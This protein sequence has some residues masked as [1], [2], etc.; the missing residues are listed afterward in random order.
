MNTKQGQKE[1]SRKE[2]AKWLAP[3]LLNLSTE[4][5]RGTKSFIQPSERTWGR[6]GKFQG[7]PS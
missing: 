4:M 7:N 6:G 3:E 5:T 1:Q 2:K